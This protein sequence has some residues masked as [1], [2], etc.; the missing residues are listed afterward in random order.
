MSNFFKTNSLYN[1]YTQVVER[2][3]F[4]ETTGAGTYTATVKVPVGAVVT[5]VIVHNTAVWTTSAAATL[6]IGDASDV[7][8]Y[9]AAVNVKTTPA[10]DTLGGMGG[11]SNLLQGSGSGA[12]KG[13]TKL[14]ETG[15]LITGTITTAAGSTGVAGRTKLLVTYGKPVVVLATKA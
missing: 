5:D 9:F 6:Q 7:D 8:G 15:G 3:D 12:Y 14:Y 1:P 2:R 10:A 13:L 11:T 4:V